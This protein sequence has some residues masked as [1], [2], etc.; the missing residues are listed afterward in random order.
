LEKDAEKKTSSQ[1]SHFSKLLVSID[2]GTSTIH[3]AFAPTAT[4][5]ILLD[6]HHLHIAW[7]SSCPDLSIVT[8][9]SFPYFR[10]HRVQAPRF[11]TTEK[12]EDKVGARGG[13]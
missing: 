8:D 7:V 2:E 9:G 10:L 1:S 4:F 12:S 6:L 5:T 11:L 13:T 3:R